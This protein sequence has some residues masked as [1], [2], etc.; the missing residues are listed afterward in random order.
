MAFCVL[1]RYQNQNLKNIA[2]LLK[3]GIIFFKILTKIMMVLAISHV[4]KIEIIIED[5][6]LICSKSASFSLKFPAKTIRVMAI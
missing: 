3:I 4:K 5:T 6:Y 1:K 2:H